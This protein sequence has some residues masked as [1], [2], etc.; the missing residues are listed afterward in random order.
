MPFL[1]GHWLHISPQCGVIQTAEHCPTPQGLR[2]D[3]WGL[4]PRVAS[5]F[6]E[7]WV[8]E[9]DLPSAM[10]KCRDDKASSRCFWGCLFLATSNAGHLCFICCPVRMSL[11]LSNWV[12]DETRNCNA[13]KIHSQG[14]AMMFKD[15][16]PAGLHFT[17]LRYTH[18]YTCIHTYLY[19]C[20]RAHVCVCICAPL[21]SALGKSY[22]S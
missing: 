21:P 16:R 5:L 2:G 13:A 7:L 14:T 18:T 1:S 15:V 6:I 17:T 10:S 4:L 19:V 3:L 11:L 20:V 8:R 9:W 22:L 12:V